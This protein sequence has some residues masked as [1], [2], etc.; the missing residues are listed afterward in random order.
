MSR[1]RLLRV[2]GAGVCLQFTWE[3]TFIHI[4]GLQPEIEL[5]VGR[6]VLRVVDIRSADFNEVTAA[7]YDEAFGDFE[8]F[9]R[10]REQ[11]L[12]EILRH[13]GTHALITAATGYLHSQYKEHKMSSSP[14]GLFFSSVRR[15]CI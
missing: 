8:I 4:R 5:A 9:M 11:D 6:D 3:A 15:F 13:R 10:W 12:V 7:K 1:E 2:C 14:A